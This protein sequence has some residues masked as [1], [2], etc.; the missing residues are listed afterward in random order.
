MHTN[1][2][3]SLRGIVWLIFGVELGNPVGVYEQNGGCSWMNKLYLCWDCIRDFVWVMFIERGPTNIERTFGNESI[4]S[5]FPFQYW[6]IKSWFKN[7]WLVYR[8]YY[9]EIFKLWKLDG[10]K[11]DPNLKYKKIANILVCWSLI[12][13]IQLAEYVKGDRSLIYSPC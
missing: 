3:S 13:M 9:I 4:W 5:V 12:I 11:N 7:T 1:A 2:A 6:D 8:I 10:I